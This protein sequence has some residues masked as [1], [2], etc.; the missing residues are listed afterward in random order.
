MQ[1]EVHRVKSFMAHPHIAPFGRFSLFGDL[2][3]LNVFPFLRTNRLLAK[4]LKE[5]KQ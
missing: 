4:F 3:L 2:L 5:K 1:R